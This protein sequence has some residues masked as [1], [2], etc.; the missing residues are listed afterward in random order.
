MHTSGKVCDCVAQLTEGMAATRTMTGPGKSCALP[1]PSLVLDPAPPCS[2][3][4]NNGNTLLQHSHNI[5]F[6]SFTYVSVVIAYK[7]M[8]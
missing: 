5:I 6:A 2:T 8:N 4:T 1:P 7:V 3:I